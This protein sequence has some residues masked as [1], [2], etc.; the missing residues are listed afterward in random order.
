MTLHMDTPF[1]WNMSVPLLDEGGRQRY[2]LV[3]DAFGLRRRLRVLDLS[4][5]E[6]VSI[7]QTV[8]S[9][10]PRFELETYGKP[11][12]EVW[13]DMTV[14]PARAVMDPRGWTAEGPMGADDVTVSACFRPG[15]RPDSP[16]GCICPGSSG[17]PSG[18]PVRFCGSGASAAVGFPSRKAQYLCVLPACTTK[19]GDPFPLPP[20]PADR[21]KNIPGKP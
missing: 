15:D 18:H 3:G 7:R 9:L 2:H 13:K 1:R 6:A 11:A 10:L 17:I 16:G 14:S 12:G 20:R 4:G 19:S 5:R 8:P 21:T